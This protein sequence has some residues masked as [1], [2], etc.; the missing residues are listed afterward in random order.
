MKRGNIRNMIHETEGNKR[1]TKGILGRNLKCPRSE[2]FT[3]VCVWIE[4]M[5][6][7]HFSN[8]D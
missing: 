1:Q 7:M 4:S 2:I 5:I 6:K 8:H 3:D